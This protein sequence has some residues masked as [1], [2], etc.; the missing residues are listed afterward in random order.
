MVKTGH[1]FLLTTLLYLDSVSNLQFTPAVEYMTVAIKSPTTKPI[2]RSVLLVGFTSSRGPL[3][4]KLSSQARWNT[5]FVQGVKRGGYRLPGSDEVC[6]LFA[7]IL[8]GC[9]S[10]WKACHGKWLGNYHLDRKRY[11]LFNSLSSRGGC[12]ITLWRQWLTHGSMYADRQIL[13]HV[14]S[15]WFVLVFFMSCF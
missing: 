5:L 6:C 4:S 9:K 14:R 15:Q 13:Y 3:E 1:R 2:Y 12:F 10:E 11:Y 8:L 7:L